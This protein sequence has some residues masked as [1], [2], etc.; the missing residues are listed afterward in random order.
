MHVTGIIQRLGQLN[1]ENNEM[2][3]EAITL[4]EAQLS[5]SV[6]AEVDFDHFADFADPFTT[7][8][9]CHVIERQW[10]ADRHQWLLDFEG[11]QLQL[12]YEFYGDVCWLSV[13]RIDDID[14]LIYLAGRLKSQITFHDV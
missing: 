5:L 9:D 13:S 6:Q 1:I 11:C 7:I 3:I 2:K 8:L 12:H 4:N 14:V 10:G